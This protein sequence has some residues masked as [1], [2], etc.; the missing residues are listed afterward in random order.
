MN[1]TEKSRF[2]LS[3]GTPEITISLETNN[4]KYDL[5]DKCIVLYGILFISLYITVLRRYTG[6]V[7]IHLF[8]HCGTQ[9]ELTQHKEHTQKLYKYNH[10]YEK[11]H[12]NIYRKSQNLYAE[13]VIPL[14]VTYLKTRL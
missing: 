13:I 11:D 9:S 3:L 8:A 5:P 2:R 4:I 7:F 6:L 1:P 14:K 10:R 12:S